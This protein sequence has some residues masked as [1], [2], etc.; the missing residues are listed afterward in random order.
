MHE[1]AVRHF[2][3]APPIV[4]PDHFAA[5]PC[6]FMNDSFDM[7]DIKYV[8][9]VR[10]YEGLNYYWFEITFNDDTVKFY[11]FA[12]KA[13]AIKCHREMQRAYTM[14]EEFAYVEQQLTES[15]IPPPADGS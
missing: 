4:Q 14:T 9:G 12:H 6:V 13:S 2:Q 15:R 3:I 8:S 5:R 10:T 1:V 7:C 11:R